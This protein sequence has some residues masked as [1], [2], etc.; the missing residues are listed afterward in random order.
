MEHQYI[1]SGMSCN[2]CRTKV[3]KT[4]NEIEGIHAEVNLNPGEA[5]ITMDKHVATEKLQEALSAAGNYTIEMKTAENAVKSCCSSKKEHSHHDHAKKAAIPHNATGVFYCPMHCEGD[6]TYN[7]PGDC[8]VCGMDLVPQIAAGTQFT[9]PMHPEVISNE[10]GDCP[11]CGMDLVPIQ[12]S[13]SE[14]NK[15]YT[16]LLKKMKIATLFTLPIFIISMSEMIP[17]NPLFKIM[18][19]EKWNWVQFIFSIPVLFYAGWI[20]FVRAWKSITTWNLNMFTLIGIGTSVAFLFSIAGMFF[21]DI[22]PAEFKSHHGTIHLY[23]E[24]ATVITTLVILG[25]LLEARAHGQTN[26]AIKELLKLAPTEATLVENGNDKVISIHNIKKGDLLR[27]KPGEKIPV[28]GKITSGESSIDEAMITG[29]PIPVDKKTGDNVIAGTI[30]GTKSFVMTAEK[31]GSETL[32]SQIIQ[33]VNDASRSRAPIQ[34]L[35]DRVAKYFVPTVVGISILTFIIWAKF[36]PEPSYIYGLINAIAVLIIAC[37]C[38]LGLATP[39]SV[40]VGVG[41]GAQHGILIKNAEALEN[42]N[43]IDVLITDKTGTIT[44][45]KPTVEKIY[46]I[47]NNEDFLL[48]NIASLNQHS[49]HPL[50]QAVVNFAKEKNQSLLEVPNFEAVAGKGVL[51]TVNNSKTALGNK[52]LMDQIGA[53][54]PDDL[55][56]KIIAEQNLGKTVSY[57]AVNNKAVGYVSITDAVKGTSAKAI[58]DLMDQGIEVIMLTGDNK[59]TAKAVA[60][61]LHLSSF[62]ADCLPEDKLKEIERLQ[63]EGKVVAMAGDGINDAPALAKADIGIA[64]GT[65]TDV[66][67]ESAKITLVKGDLNGIVKAHKLSFCVMKNIKQNLFFAFIYNVLGVPIAA[68]I[69]YPVFGIL[70]SPMLAALAM[71]LSSVSVIAN[72]L[73]LRNLNL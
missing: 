62:K 59:N 61:H 3:E 57:I 22:F 12:A 15:T 55:E 21:P 52:K 34:K 7:K 47:D 64:M 24:A 13:E 48:Q 45:G 73:R 51:G 9:C 36:G 28:D 70:L 32:L 53:S 14:D 65:G 23:F 18:S 68:G 35:A 71:S 26:G 39:M 50:A 4:L 46:A 43:K 41:K 44:E 37:P 42:M 8:P 67:I 20:F 10:P 30:N 5:T 58:K 27:V 31:V 66:A 19:I 6:K 33:M 60:D 11:I 49:E 40:M 56:T 29:E 69:L 72:A 54:I 63:A 38:A 17:D 2:G 16:D 25:Q 1:I